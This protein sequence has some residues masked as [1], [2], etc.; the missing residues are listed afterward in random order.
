MEL[1]DVLDEHGNKNGSH[2]YRGEKLGN[3]QYHLV[4]E[5]WPINDN[6]ELFIQKRTRSKQT[7]PGMWAVTG[8]SAIA[9]EDAKTA[10]IRE[11]SEEVGI[12]LKRDD[13]NF[14][15]TMKRRSAIIYVYTTK[16]SFDI[17]DVVMQEEEVSDVKWANKHEIQEMQDNGTFVN[18]GKDYFDKLFSVI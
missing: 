13:L 8:G 10:A 16:K 2:I 5:I 3:N 18:F 6:K 17:K 9:G 7:H 11:F 4:V 1:W 12:T 14:A 15:F